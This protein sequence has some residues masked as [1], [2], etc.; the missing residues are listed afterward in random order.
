MPFVQ[1]VSIWVRM[2]RIAQLGE[3]A[4]EAAEHRAH[5]GHEGRPV[6]GHQR[7]R[8]AAQLDRLAQDVEDRDAPPWS[9]TARMPSRKRLWSSTSAT[10]WQVRM[11]PPRAVQVERA[12][13]VDVPQLVG[14][15]PLVA[16]TGD[17]AVLGRWVP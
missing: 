10:K 15:R 13:E 12:L 2:W 14:A 8:D 4:L 1:G 16:R 7:E 11:G 5:D 9:G 3:R 6:V 17:P